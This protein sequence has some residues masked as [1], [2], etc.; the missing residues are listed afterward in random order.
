[1]RASFG[2]RFPGNRAF[3]TPAGNSIFSVFGLIELFE[4]LEHIPGTAAVCLNDTAKLGYL[5]SAIRHERDLGAVYAQLQTDQLRGKV[6]FAQACQELH[7]RCEAIRADNLLDTKFKPT[8]KAL[9][10]TEI[11][12]LDKE[13]LPCLVKGC[14][15]MIVSFLPLC[16]GCFLQCESGKIAV[17][18][19]RDGKAESSSGLSGL[20]PHRAQFGHQH[21]RCL[22]PGKDISIV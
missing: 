4:D 11:E 3:G 20:E 17:L 14:E 5:L 9:I 15:R 2:R 13:K 16:K 7:F 12:H 8:G 10:S 18:E 22:G 1:L 6:T 21:S 19:L